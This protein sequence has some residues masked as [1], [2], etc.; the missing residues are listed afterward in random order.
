M[1]AIEQLDLMSVGH[2]HASQF[3]GWLLAINN[4]LLLSLA[5]LPCLRLLVLF[6][7]FSIL[8]QFVPIIRNGL[9]T[10]VKDTLVDILLLDVGFGA[11]FV[12]GKL[13]L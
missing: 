7:S 13:L 10:V 8:T 11:A 2:D 3:V 9:V 5:L 1:L 4:L 6:G 12:H